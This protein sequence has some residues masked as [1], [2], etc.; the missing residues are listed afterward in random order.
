M[1][2]TVLLAGVGALMVPVIYIG[3]DDWRVARRLRK[4]Q[5]PGPGRHGREER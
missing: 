2:S 4:Q 3:F 5:E 1:I